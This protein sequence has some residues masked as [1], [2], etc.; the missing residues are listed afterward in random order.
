[1]NHTSHFRAVR[2]LSG[3][4]YFFSI[5]IFIN[6]F[7]FQHNPPSGWQQQFLPFL[8]NRPLADM[9][10]V[11]SLVGIGITGDDSVN[12]TNYIIKT[13]DGGNKWFTVGNYFRDFAKVKF[14]DK[15][16]GFICG[17]YN[18]LGGG[19]LLKTTNTGDT[20]Q[21]VTTGFGIY[22]NDM[23]I[24]NA[25]TIWL[26]DRLF[27]G[28]LF[29]TTDGGV[30]W[31]RQYGG[32]TGNPEGIYMYNSQLGFM[33]RLDNTILSRT[34]DGGFT[35]IDIPGVLGFTDL[36]FNDSL[37]GWKAVGNMKRTTD[38]GITWES[39]V[40]PMVYWRNLVDMSVTGYDTIYGVGG[41]VDLPPSS[42]IGIVFKTTNGGANWGFQ[43]PDSLFRRYRN[44]DFVNSTTGWAY[45][46]GGS[47]GVHTTT[48]GDTNTIFTG[49]ENSSSPEQVSSFELL[50]NYPNPFNPSTKIKFILTKR[51]FC[52]L[53]V[54]D[55]A[56]REV[57]ELI[58]REYP[59]GEWEAEF[60]GIGLAGGVYFARLEFTTK[61][62]I[63]GSDVVK[64][65]LIK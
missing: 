21:Q 3:L 47:W 52:R 41:S 22:Y 19:I 10:F 55:I 2:V 28:G 58:S 48:G 36:H 46:R 62:G 38:G 54:F 59:D 18:V 57:R 11:D 64:M 1:M 49:I 16:T 5:F 42:E 33:S 37:N 20:W 15:K 63:A 17:G 27:N 24:L 6:A 39:Q 8:N 23:S 43:L 50:Q 29:R 44:E 14:I 9:D 35:W 53:A 30:S 32:I 13:T 51:G 4:F 12:D 40:L 26:T 25:D 65:L 7:N 31:L 56:G 61:N 60:D 45:S 34:T